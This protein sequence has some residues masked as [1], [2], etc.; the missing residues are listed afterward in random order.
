ML[1]K[2]MKMVYN[3]YSTKWVCPHCDCEISYGAEGSM[4]CPN[5][6]KWMIDE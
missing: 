3:K 4:R 6:G 5:C 2:L 1:K